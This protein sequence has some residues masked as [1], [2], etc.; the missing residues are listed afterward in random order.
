MIIPNLWKNTSHVPNH[1]QPVMALKELFLRQKIQRADLPGSTSA[2]SVRACSFACHLSANRKNQTLPQP[3]AIRSTTWTREQKRGG[4]S[5]LNHF[6]RLGSESCPWLDLMVEVL[7]EF[8]WSKI[9][10]SVVFFQHHSVSV[11]LKMGFPRQCL[12]LNNVEHHVP[13]WNSS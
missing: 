11:C 6:H 1:H 13:Q 12:W 5:S 9:E 10:S 4:G 8:H 2:A 3:L 7:V